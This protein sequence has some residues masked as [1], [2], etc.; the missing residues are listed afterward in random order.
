MTRRYIGATEVEKAWFA[1]ANN[2]APCEYRLTPDNRIV[3]S[4]SPDDGELVGV[5]DN[6][7]L[8]EDFRAD[9]R[10]AVKLRRKLERLA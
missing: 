3:C 5:Y 7:V 1:T 10:F 2:R 6:N 9:V 4:E 8:L